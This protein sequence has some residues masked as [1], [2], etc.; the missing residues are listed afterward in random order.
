MANTNFFNSLALPKELRDALK[1]EIAEPD[2]SGGGSS[3]ERSI[4][5]VSTGNS[6]A[7][8]TDD[9]IVFTADGT[10][11]ELLL[12]ILA[13]PDNTVGEGKIYRV[14]YVSYGGAPADFTV[15]G[16]TDEAGNI[17][18]FFTTEGTV[19]S[20]LMP[21]GGVVEF[22]KI[23][24]FNAGD[25]IYHIWTVFGL[26]GGG[27]PGPQGPQGDPGL[28]STLSI[29]APGATVANMLIGGQG[30][31]RGSVAGFTVSALVQFENIPAGTEVICGNL[32]W[33]Q[34]D[35][36]WFI[37][38]DSTG[39]KFG[40]GQA[41]DGTIVENF[42][43]AAIPNGFL[44]IAWPLS[45][46][47]LFYL[48][49]KVSGTT[50]SF[51]IN[52][53]LSGTITLTG[54]YRPATATLYPM[55]FRNNNIGIPLNAVAS[56]LCCLWYS[57]VVFADQYIRDEFTNVQKHGG[58]LGAFT[59]FTSQFYPSVGSGGICYLPDRIGSL[60]PFTSIDGQPTRE[61]IPYW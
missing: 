2:P 60:T 1:V 17:A 26:G 28:L 18:I 15:A 48:T 38:A 51:Y 61:L 24:V 39:W 42:A 23:G 9:S 47:R 44:D 58:P 40:A 25:D 46:N 30:E 10:E 55:I 57:Q 31:M 49:L 45:L 8:P 43:G 22:E 13:G 6:I 11:R 32:N 27:T 59:Y 3:S 16:E 41:S 35:G 14:E 36:G 20:V 53:R 5:T 33:A 50:A 37:G 4:R 29:M 19:Q 56:R 34:P 7:T 52:G 54:G 12:P 21:F